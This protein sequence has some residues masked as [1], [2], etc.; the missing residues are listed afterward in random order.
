MQR[1]G[2]VAIELA[3]ARQGYPV[4]LVEK[5]Q[6]LGGHAR[7]LHRVYRGAAVADYIKALIREVERH[8]GITLHLGSHITRVDGFVG[9]F[10]S[11]VTDGSSPAT[12]DHGVAILATGAQA[13]TPKAYLYGEHP[14][15][16]THLE[17][18]ALLRDN[19]ARLARAQNVAFIQCVGSRD[20]EHPY[21]SKVCCTHTLVSALALKEMDPE[22]TIAVLYRDMRAFGTRERL[23]Q[24]ARARGVLF[25]AY[26][27]E[28]P[29]LA[30][31]CGDR[32]ALTF[33][34]P[35]LDRA[36]CM[37]ADLL[38]LAT[39][40][41]SHR[42]QDLA[43]CFKVSMDQDG[44][45][46]EAHQ[47]LRPVE[48]AVDGVF[49]CGLAHYPKTL[50]ESIAQAQAAVSRALSVLSRQAIRVGG[51]VARIDA[52]QCC[53][54]RGCIEVCPYGAIIFNADEKKSEVNAALC[55]GCGACAAACP[56]EA[57]ELM[58]FNTRQIY[59]QIRSG[60]AA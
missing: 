59:A 25:F 41:V 47:K 15:V 14:A 53:G 4:H 10:Q 33:Q 57:V 56:A 3:L 51:Q 9:N 27:P 30:E 42:D 35:I 46:Q 21:C 1:A 31:A 34:D 24:E 17:M 6:V 38:C 44:W 43:Q 28:K 19:D 60:L 11:Q 50:E 20:S 54:C 13:F 45:L 37:E 5:S 2:V 52:D 18:D 32:V 16:V 49:L 7:N 8:P 22:K 55:K 26:T 48:F 12:I 29:P 40:I 23:Y 36:V 58:G 39:A